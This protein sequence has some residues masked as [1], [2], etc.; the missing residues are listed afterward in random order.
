MDLPAP[1]F[2]CGERAITPPNCQRCEQ[3]LPE[4]DDG[5]YMYTICHNCWWE[6]DGDMPLYAYSFCNGTTLQ[7]AKNNYAEY[8]ACSSHG[9]WCKTGKYPPHNCADTEPMSYEMGGGRGFT[10]DLCSICHEP[11][12]GR[13]KH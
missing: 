5:I 9:L 2:F 4:T 12:P 10:E 6:Q 7:Q 3:R 1:P 13:G 11:H 8:G